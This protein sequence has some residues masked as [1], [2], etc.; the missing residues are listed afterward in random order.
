MPY[1][2]SGMGAMVWG[3]KQ[4][5]NWVSAGA[6]RPAPDPESMAGQDTHPAP[7]RARTGRYIEG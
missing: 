6:T 5:D 1:A 2:D 3:D 4:G 7:S